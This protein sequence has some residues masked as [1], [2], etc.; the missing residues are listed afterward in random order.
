MNDDENVERYMHQRY[1]TFKSEVILL[2]KLLQWKTVYK[3]PE[4]NL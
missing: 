2:K 1:S 3:K 4:K